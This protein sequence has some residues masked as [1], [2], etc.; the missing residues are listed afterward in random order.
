MTHQLITWRQS[1]VHSS[2]DAAT[3]LVVSTNHSAVNHTGTV[4]SPLLT[5]EFACFDSKDVMRLRIAKAIDQ[6]R[7]VEMDGSIVR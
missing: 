4:L 1:W 3:R 2:I 7:N 6:T 5:I